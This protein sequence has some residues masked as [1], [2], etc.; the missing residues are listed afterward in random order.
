MYEYQ[1][2]AT[3]FLFN[4][5]DP[6]LGGRDGRYAG[7]VE[8]PTV[9]SFF[10]LPWEEAIKQIDGY[11]LPPSKQ[12][13]DTYRDVLKKFDTPDRIQSVI[14]FLTEELT[15]KAKK[16]TTPTVEQIYDYIE[17]RP[18]EFR[19]EIRWIMLQ[20]KRSWQGY[21]CFIK[22]RPT[23]L[24]GDYYT[25]L[26]DCEIV[27][28]S[29]EKLGDGKPNYK[30]VDRRIWLFMRWCETTTEALFRYKLCGRE[31]GKYVERYFNKS[32]NAI[33]HA[34]K[35]MTFYTL[36]EGDFYRDMKRRTVNGFVLA[37][38]RGAGKTYMMGHK[39]TK[40][41]LNIRNG[42]FAVQARSEK[43]AKA[44]VFTEKI[45]L[46]FESMRFFHKPSH[47]LLEDGIRFYPRVRAVIDA[48]IIPH[49]GRIFS[50]SS[51]NTAV[52]GNRTQAYGNDESG[53]EKSGQILNDH[54]D[55][56]V[57]MLQVN[58][59]IIGLGMYVSTF[60]EFEKGGKAF[61][62]LMKA[63]KSHER[64]DNGRTIT[65]MVANFIPAF[66][67]FDDCVDEFGESII[68]DPEE[69]YINMKGVRM[70]IGAR[71]Y[72]NVEREHL[73]D[74]GE[75]VLL[76][77]AIRNDPF[78]MREA[79][80]K[81]TTS[82]TVDISIVNKR[83]EFLEFD[84]SAPRGREVNLEWEGGRRF[85]HVEQNGVLT[86]TGQLANVII[87][88]PRP[89]ERGKFTIFRQPPDEWKNKKQYNQYTGQWGPDPSFMHRHV[90]GADPFAM[91]KKDTTGKKLSNGGGLIFQKRDH[92][93][94]PDDMN[95]ANWKTN[96]TAATY[97][98][99]ADTTDEYWDDMLKACVLWSCR[100]N[101]ERNI[102]RGIENF[103]KWKCAEYL[104][105]LTDPVTGELDPVPGVRTQGENKQTLFALVRDYVKQHGHRECSVEVLQQILDCES[106]EDLTDN[107][108]YASLGVALM[109]SE[110]P[111]GK[112]LTDEESGVLDM[113]DEV[114]YD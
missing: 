18:V 49:K 21:W 29:R 114:M 93:I 102:T 90:T 2:E 76:N 60:G 38:R 15:I 43:T 14:D 53:K 83:L 31:N 25:Y 17:E 82:E 50:R 33:L 10:G 113:S 30:D 11:G 91:D 94:D 56:I 68:E 67:G 106:L 52:D 71:T 35:K 105:H 9:E 74:Q 65:G 92:N 107:D 12:K 13:F 99:R 98:V 89:G 73:R 37:T 4:Q 77:K 103:R 80:R 84:D 109:G 69:P 34:R 111:H 5:Y 70:E 100:M 3:F 62:Q 28:A 101:T 81:A 26:T 39:G 72:F 86:N 110:S 6:D 75:W 97:N 40:R 57:H 27:N 87:V 1:K 61:F 19:E 112:E 104:L 54:M 48:S 51:E 22:G 63:S 8:L 59:E 95:I 79:A 85:I 55:T 58:G 24:D 44:D 41:A 88:E 42:K 7:R 45:R 32:K 66:D 64:T 108:L 47:Q 46:P 36:K 23:Y 20:K 78:T 16:P 96:T